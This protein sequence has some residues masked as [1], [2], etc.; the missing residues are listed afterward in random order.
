[1]K[2]KLLF[3][4][5]SLISVS[6]SVFGQQDKLITHF[7]YDKMSLNP[8][9]TG[10]DQGICAT[11]IY[12]NQWDKVNG[13]PNSAILNV[14][15]NLA[16]YNVPVGVGLSFYH[17]AIGFTRQ[18]NLLLNFSYPVPLTIGQLGIGLGVGMQNIGMNPD[19]VP[20]VTFNDPS[21]PTGFAATN[22]DLNFGLYL[23]A[24]SGYYVGLS[25]THLTAPGFEAVSSLNASTDPIIYNSVRHYYIMGG[26]RQANLFHQGGDLE[27][28]ILFRTD[29]VKAS[30]D[31]NVRYHYFGKAYGGLTYRTSDAV[32]VMLGADIM[33]WINPPTKNAIFDHFIVGYSYDITLNKLSN[34]SQGSHEIL[35]KYCYYLPPIPIQKS[36]HPRWL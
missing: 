34:I 21:L 11:T 9:E 3:F 6:A 32:A 25:S 15:G 35:L 17:D 30:A 31:I 12:R 18:N 19:W 4:S 36:K 14:E 8:G 22:L 2:K 7:M 23:K 28:N 1:M 16:Q 10:L 5:L 20:P 13:A 26:H 33:K 24:T 29:A 27:G